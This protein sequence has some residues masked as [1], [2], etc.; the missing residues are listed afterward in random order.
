MTKDAHVEVRKLVI[1]RF[2]SL[3]RELLKASHEN[4]SKRES[5]HKIEEECYSFQRFV[6]SEVNHLRASIPQCRTLVESCLKI[7]LT[8]CGVNV[9]DS[10]AENEL[11]LKRHLKES[12]DII[13]HH[14]IK[15]IRMGSN[16]KIHD[17]KS[18]NQDDD[19]SA[20]LIFLTLYVLE[21]FYKGI[22]E[23]V[24]TPELKSESKIE[25][26]IEPKFE[27]LCISSSDDIIVVGI[28]DHP[29]VCM[30]NACGIQC[31][32]QCAEHCT[33]N[34][35]YLSFTTIGTSRCLFGEDCKK[36][37][38]TIRM[39]SGQEVSI[40][41][42]LHGDKYD[43]AKRKIGQKWSAYVKGQLSY[44]DLAAPVEPCIETNVNLISNKRCK[45]LPCMV[46]ACGIDCGRGCTE[47]SDCN[48][49][50]HSYTKI[51]NQKCEFGFACSKYLKK[52][53]LEDGRICNHCPFLHG[54]QSDAVKKRLGLG[55]EK[56]SK[57]MIAYDQ[58]F[59]DE[60]LHE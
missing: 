45:F 17:G 25:P 16:K 55:W 40:C 37:K 53:H 12:E 5:L 58:I 13:L 54:D 20:A 36:N 15:T 41:Q 21:K 42:Y 4:K 22:A 23:L 43:D 11:A 3:S 6:E 33:K 28:K 56:Y 35:V 50:Y 30:E 29:L 10:F 60:E 52:I 57:G 27:K 38:K 24:V 19:E 34:Q 8:Y 18:G 48:T 51:G 2:S 49:V 59:T 39:P 32:R 9:H 44:S 26:K 1:S 31:R 47:H 7:Y 46:N 14:Y